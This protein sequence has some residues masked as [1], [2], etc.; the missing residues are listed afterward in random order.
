MHH[1]LMILEPRGRDSKTGAR[2]AFTM[3]E[4]LVVVVDIAVLAAIMLPADPPAKAASKATRCL[5]HKNQLQLGSLLYAE[6]NND[7]IVPNGEV[8]EGSLSA[9]LKYWW[10]QGTLNYDGTH[11]DNTNTSLLIDPTY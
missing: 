3:L 5:N 8:R 9:D 11:P 4:L 2:L 1:Q 6:D 10:P 7:Q